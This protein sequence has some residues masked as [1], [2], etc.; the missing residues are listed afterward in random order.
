MSP[1]RS[2]K[3]EVEYTETKKV[4]S[5]SKAVTKSFLKARQS[6]HEKDKRKSLQELEGENWGDGDHFPSYLVRTCHRLRRKPLCDFTIEDLR[7]MIGQDMSLT[8]LV[9]LAIE[10]LQRDPLAAGDFYQGDLLKSVLSVNPRFWRTRPDL[11]STLERIVNNVQSLPE[12]V[13]EALTQ[14]R[15]LNEQR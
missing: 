6:L 5:R 7:I 13:R 4:S 10:H 8:Y 1:S 15:T 9:P 2:E 12:E 11:R 14:F 3:L